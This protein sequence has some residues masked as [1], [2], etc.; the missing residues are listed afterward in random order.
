MAITRPTTQHPP[1]C[2]TRTWKMASVHRHPATRYGRRSRGADDA[3]VGIQPS[4]PRP[5]AEFGQRVT[6]L[7][8]GTVTFLFT[9]IEGSTRLIEELG[10]H[11]YVPVLAEHRRVLRSAFSTHGGVEVDTQGDAFLYAFADPV[12]ALAAAA[13]GQQ[14][15]G[16]GPV[17]VR[18]GLHTAEP[19]LTGEGYAGRE[20]HRAAR[21][22]G[23]VH[24]GQVVL[25]AAT[26]ALVDGDITELGEHRLK[27]FDDPVALFQLG[28]RRFPPLKTISNTNLPRPA[29]SFV[30]RARE[31]AEVLGLL[32]NG[33]RLVTLSGP[34]GSGKTRLAVE[35]AS[36]LVPAFK[37][38]AFWVGLA[39]LRDPA[40]VTEMIAQTLGA[41][42]G[43]ADH[44]S[45]RELLLLL[46]NFEHVVEAAPELSQLLEAC[47]R[48]T[49]LV[50]SRELLRIAGEVEYPVPALAESDAVELFCERSPLA[51]DETIAELC[52]RL[53][54]LPL[55]VEL[56]AARTRVLTPAQIVDR[57]SQRL[58]L[59]K[60]GRDADLRQQT[61]RATIGWSHDMLSGDEKQV[62]ARLSVFAGGCTLEA[63]EEVC[64][65]DVDVLQSLVEKSLLR[66]AG[67]RFWMLETIREFAAEGLAAADGSVTVWAD[68]AE[69]YASLAE[70]ADPHI[71][72]GADQLEWTARIAAEYDNI[73]T[74]VAFGLGEAS[75]IALRIIVSLSTFVWLRGGVTEA[76]TW[77]DEALA[78]G[79]D[80]PLLWR[81]RALVCQAFWAG[82]QGD[83]EAATQSANEAF[84]TTA[85]AGDEF[86]NAWA[87]LECAQ[88]AIAAGDSERGRAIYEELSEL[89]D[90]DAD[91]AWVSAIALNNL[92]DLAL[93]D[94][95]WARVI[96]FCGRSSAIRRGIGNLWGAA[97]GLVNV[98]IAQR[99]AGLLDDA[100]HS[101]HQALE[102]SL[103]VDARNVVLACFSAVAALAG[104]R[105]RPQEAAMLL[106]AHD[107][108]RE[109]L[110]TALDDFE[111]ALVEAAG[112]KTRALL[113]DHDF[114]LA[115]DH[116]RSLL[117][118]DAA[119]LALALTSET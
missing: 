38:G 47:P 69:F 33:V 116:G 100:A 98:A 46:D 82:L 58:D 16:S 55:A 60:G 84:A 36:E 28:R 94:G 111:H 67:D 76:R 20:L 24:G 80:V 106:G 91:L 23:S 75:E 2:S 107:Q 119:A 44:I 103:A 88:A 61:L 115:F 79:A 13:L 71:R 54:Y 64:A 68:H 83:V 86:G 51:P 35:V 112:R 95:D 74:A 48:L 6:E 65:A 97:L 93:Y 81:G 113:G 27:D 62:F 37:A 87:L 42:D 17:K 73:R 49:L 90:D 5:D 7:P 59:L 4:S 1:Q 104:D 109:E 25:S 8:S 40:L 19:L 53:D 45:E 32:R 21:I 78:T 114:A 31:R 12:R 14:A 15:L 11:G 66:H 10:E 43:L 22:A 34:G 63:A 117:I 101:A 30:G 26:R 96:D 85:A 72:R 77:V 57:L 41:K 29:S 50:T 70:R 3:T 56:A 92:G 52:R 105:E 108:L 110:D 9:D 99:E 18:M 39:P 102:D 118:E 89:S